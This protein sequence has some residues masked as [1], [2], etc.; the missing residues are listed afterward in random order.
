[1]VYFDTVR[2]FYSFNNAK[3]LA[4]RAIVNFNNGTYRGSGVVKPDSGWR[5]PM[6]IDT[7]LLN[8]G[9][10]FAAE[11]DRIR[12][13]L[14]KR[15]K[16][17]DA[18]TVKAKSKSKLQQMDEKYTSG[19]FSG[20]DATTFDLT[21]DPSAMGAMNIFQYLQGRVAGLQITTGGQ[22]TQLSWR[23]GKPALFLNEM[24]T[25]VS[26]IENI[27]V[28]DIA[29]VKAFRPPFFGAMGGGSGGA[30]AIYTKKGGDVVSNPSQS[31]GL[32]KQLLAGYASVKEFY[33]PDYSKETTQADVPD[34]RTTLY[35][36]P[37]ILTDKH[38]RKITLQFYNNDVS[39]RLR[40]VLEGINEEGQL[41]RVEKLIE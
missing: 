21:D 12:P 3:Q 23:Q 9:R 40:V 2:V 1:M 33:S 7:S 26:Q 30:I 35:W 28:S 22:G 16:T 6:P 31:V 24:P 29:L 41:T 32:E 19:F 25:D 34:I 20:G 14:E 18:V 10:F 39:K 11:A 8:R 13:E 17:L 36:V 4:G 15:I 38:N 37:Y 27:P 5:V